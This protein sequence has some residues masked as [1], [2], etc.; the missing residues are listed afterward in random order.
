MHIHVEVG[1]RQSGYRQASVIVFY[2]G[3]TVALSLAGTLTAHADY[4]AI[5]NE[6]CGAPSSYGCGPTINADLPIKVEQQ[7]EFK[8]DV[9]LEKKE[10]PKEI[11]SEPV[12]VFMEQTTSVSYEPRVLHLRPNQRSTIT[13]KV[14]RSPSGL[15]EI[16]ATAEGYKPLLVTIDSGFRGKLINTFPKEI[17]AGTTRSFV[18][19]FVDEK[20][21]PVSLETSGLLLVEGTAT[22]LR[23]GNSNWSNSLKFN[24]DPGETC[25]PLLQARATSGIKAN[26]SIRAQLLVNPLR[27]PPMAVATEISE[28][29][30]LPS[31]WLAMLTAAVGGTLSSIYTLGKRRSIAG[32]GKATIAKVSGTLFSGFLAGCLAYLLATWNILG[33]RVDT[34]SLRGFVVIGFLFS[35]LGIES[36]MKRIMP[37]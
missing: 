14:L 23:I 19:K 6:P 27:K 18:V 31:W 4:P 11:L 37:T 16:R 21:N 3:L 24:L 7:R 25:T 10:M 5:G 22:K 13:A 33:I 8:V 15:T 29:Q 32:R 26:G 9:W 35:Y 20:G 17:E 36:V 34:T 28:F 2:W 1:M 30:I 12:V